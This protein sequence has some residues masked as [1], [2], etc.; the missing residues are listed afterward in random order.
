MV[1]FSEAVSEQPAGVQA[2][3]HDVGDDGE[4]RLPCHSMGT[5][6]FGEHY[7]VTELTTP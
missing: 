2:R 7:I 6:E 3:S 4:S 5:E 1:S